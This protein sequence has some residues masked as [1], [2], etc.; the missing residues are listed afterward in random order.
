VDRRCFD[1][2]PDPDLYRHQNGN[3]DPDPN[4]ANS[5]HCRIEYLPGTGACSK[6][7]RLE[8]I[9]VD[10]LSPNHSEPI[11]KKPIFNFKLSVLPREA[12]IRI[13]QATFL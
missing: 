13:F 11:T 3:S 9:V 5:Q 12:Q 4:D 7:P 6:A 8:K 2:D 10:D 1:A